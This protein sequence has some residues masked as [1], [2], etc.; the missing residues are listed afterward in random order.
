MHFLGLGRVSC[1]CGA[2]A[3]IPVFFIRFYGAILA[4]LRQPGLSQMLQE[5]PPKRMK[6]RS[7]IKPFRPAFRG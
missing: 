5:M 7:T 4:F 2:R 1:F 6:I 3:A